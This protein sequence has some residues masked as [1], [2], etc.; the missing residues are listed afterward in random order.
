[1]P[2]WCENKL[3][4]EGSAIQLSNLLSNYTS[5]EEEE[6]NRCIDFN[7]IAPTPPELSE[8]SA[9]ISNDSNGELKKTLKKRYGSTDWYAW[10]VKNWGTKW[11]P[12][13]YSFEDNLEDNG[14]KLEFAFDT[15]WTPPIPIIKKLSKLYPD[16]KLTITY[17][18][19]GCCFAGRDVFKHG[20]QIGHKYTEDIKDKLF[21]DF[22]YPG[23]DEDD[24]LDT[25]GFGG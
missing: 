23:E 10:N 21:E 14:R 12:S 16:L 3:I 11:L 22:G 1:M 24:N 6:G 17:A 5:K 7:K 8:H 4:I 13:A 19:P 2:N 18:E 9:P 25:D 15:A 20:K